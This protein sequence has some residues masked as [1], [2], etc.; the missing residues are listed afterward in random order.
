MVQSSTQFS[1]LVD[2]DPVLEDIFF[3][4][5]SQVPMMGQTIFGMRQA[6]KEK[7]TDQLIGSFGDPKLFQG[8]VEYDEALPDFDVEYSFPEY[9]NGFLITR[10]MLDDMQYDTI[11]DRAENLGQSFVRWEE[12]EKADILNGAFAGSTGYDAKVLCADDH[13]RS[14]SDSTS[15][16]NLLTAALS[17]DSL[18]TSLVQ[19]ANLGDDRGEQTSVMGN[20]LVVPWQL[21][22]TAFELVQSELTP[23]NANNAANVHAGMKFMVWP[24]LTSA[25]AW[26]VL[27]TGKSKLWLKWYDRI[28][29][30]FAAVD[31][32]DTLIRK[33]RAY[34][35][36]GLGYSNFRFLVG[37]TGAG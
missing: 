15:V 2:L 20:L 5:Y 31:S 14:E 8:K 3:Q 32:F 1:S 23:E 28:Q 33:F 24:F 37:S 35:R 30:E 7:V 10:K 25:T 27:D 13:P 34:R 6:T 26:Y 22:K 16:D 29:L 21:R 4:A 17:T 9:T 12:K 19:L 18:E 11:F 36:L